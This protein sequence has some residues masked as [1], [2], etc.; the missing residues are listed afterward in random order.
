M[1]EEL[2]EELTEEQIQAKAEADLAKGFNRVH[3]TS[4]DAE[5]PKEEPIIEAKE[6]EPEEKPEAPQEPSTASAAEEKLQKRIRDLE[7]HIGG[8]RNQYQSLQETI[9]ETGK[10]PTDSQIKTALSDPEAMEKLMKEWEE[11]KPITNELE[12][13]RAD[14]AKVQTPD[15]TTF[16]KEIN[17]SIAST[18]NQLREQMRLDIKHPE[19][20]STVKSDEFI[21]YALEGGPSLTEYSTMKAYESIEPARAEAMVKDW[22]D[23]FQ[24]WWDS[25]G[26]SYFSDK[27]NDAIKLLDGYEEYRKGEK[28]RANTEDRK[29]KSE[30]RLEAAVQPE[31]AGGGPPE[32]SDNERF[33]RGFYRV[34]GP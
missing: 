2:T 32:P 27:A 21:L 13:L 33:K 5:P 7:G 29:R 4:D 12:A 3:S 6:P 30:Q 28:K 10:G 11:F 23:K 17:T 14:L 25:R 9:K 15:L 22:Q 1:T 26:S 34:H 19:W 16:R 18:T 31:G 8:L 24:K 20:E